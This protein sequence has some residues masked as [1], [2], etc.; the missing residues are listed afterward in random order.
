MAIPITLC[1]L[2]ASP[3]LIAADTASDTERL[4]QQ[5]PVIP[6]LKKAAVIATGYESSGIDVSSTAHR[7]VITVTDSK[8]LQATSMEREREASKIASAIAKTIAGKTPFDQVMLI[9]VDYVTRQGGQ[10]KVVNSI[11]FAKDPKGVFRH[12]VS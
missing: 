6:D 7:I 1:L 4:K 10:S 5:A 12:H 9:R 8:L 11:D 3:L 2:W